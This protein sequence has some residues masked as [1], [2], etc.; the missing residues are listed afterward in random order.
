MLIAVKCLQYLSHHPHRRQEEGEEEEEVEGEVE[1]S[2]EEDLRLHLDLDDNGT[3]TNADSDLDGRSEGEEAGESISVRG[4]IGPSRKRPA[5]VEVHTSSQKRRASEPVYRVD[6]PFPTWWPRACRS[7]NARHVKCVVR[8][9]KQ[10]KACKLTGGARQCEH[11]PPP[12]YRARFTA[13]NRAASVSRR[14][15]PAVERPARTREG[16]SLGEDIV[17]SLQEAAASTAVVRAGEAT[18]VQRGAPVAAMQPPRQVVATRPIIR[19]S[20]VAQLCDRPATED[21]TRPITRPT[22]QSTPKPAIRSVTKPAAYPATSKT[23]T[24]PVTRPA[25]EPLTQPGTDLVTRPA[26]QVTTQSLSNLPT[27]PAG[28]A[29]TRPTSNATTQPASN[30]NATTLPAGDIATRP[31]SNVTTQPASNVTTRPISN[32][33]TQ[34]TSNTTTRP[35]SNTTTQPTSN[36]TTQPTSNTTTQ[37]TSNTTTQPISNTTTQPTSITTTQPANH[38]TTHSDARPVREALAQPTVKPT[39]EIVNAELEPNVQTVAGSG[40]A[41]LDAYLCLYLHGQEGLAGLVD[42]STVGT[43]E[44]LL[45]LVEED[46]GLHPGS[47]EV[48][49]LER[50]DGE[51]FQRFGESSI[52]IKRMGRHDLWVRFLRPMMKDDS[53]R[54]LRACIATHNSSAGLEDEGMG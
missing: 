51:V 9:G 23:I 49:H 22:T 32:T 26:V 31:T 35:T 43:R 27:Q 18:T 11:V 25:L 15:S 42:L 12:G 46:L 36:T 21:A 41:P 38:T 5:P 29:A 52:P 7:C 37:P 28:N 45:D 44:D 33:T 4:A 2:E 10:C 50:A 3:T 30:A 16:H 19:I 8:V 34:P 39:T 20:T 48:I 47:L 17:G 1:E 40:T 54:D 13:V 6:T 24:D 14:S 53:I